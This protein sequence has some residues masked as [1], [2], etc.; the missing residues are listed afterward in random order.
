MLN[1]ILNIVGITLILYSI[2]IIKKDISV[3]KNNLDNIVHTDFLEEE[4]YNE[5]YYQINE[6]IVKNFG[7]LIDD[8][9]HFSDLEKDQTKDEVKSYETD[10][11]IVPIIKDHR[12]ISTNDKLNPLHKKVMELKSL[13]LT[14]EEIARK[15]GKGIR[16]IDII[17]KIGKKDL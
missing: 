17:L 1:I 8:K 9:I 7:L 16:E 3:K 15:M 2:F 6:E 12:K 4:L 10:K 14:H 11:I 5:E 13:G